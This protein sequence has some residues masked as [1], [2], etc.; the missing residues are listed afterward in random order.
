M[1]RYLY[2]PRTE[3]IEATSVEALPSGVNGRPATSNQEDLPAPPPAP[4]IG[5]PS[6]GGGTTAGMGRLRAPLR[7]YSGAAPTLPGAGTISSGGSAAESSGTLT[8]GI[9]G[10]TTP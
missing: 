2:S 5:S 6:F 1:S 7:P 3:L 8:Q 4:T 10:D 9:W